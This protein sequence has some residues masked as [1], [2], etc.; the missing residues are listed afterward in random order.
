MLQSQLKIK[1]AVNDDRGGVKG[2][3]LRNQS[4]TKDYLYR[5]CYPLFRSIFD[6]YYTDCAN[7]IE[8]ISEIYLF[9]MIPSSLTGRSKLEGFGFKCTLAMWLKIVAE[10]YCRSLFV[11]KAEKE[12]LH[13]ETAD[14]LDFKTESIDEKISSLDR[15]DVE[16]ILSM[17]RNDRYRNIMRLRYLE[18]RDNEET[19]EI[20][21]MTMANY[22]N[23]HKLAKEQFCEVLRKEG[24]I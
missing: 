3:L 8:F 7:C 11:K 17:M 4:I 16:K 9:I 19:A 22:Y 5:K 21:G 24:L 15:G 10:N 1:A 13:F 20:L 14:R 12:P 23:K 2:L 6:R 18:D